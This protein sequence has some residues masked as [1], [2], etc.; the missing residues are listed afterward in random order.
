MGR[1]AR[2]RKEQPEEFAERC[3]SSAD[4]ADRELPKLDPP[5]QPTYVYTYLV[6]KRKRV[7]KK[8]HRVKTEMSLTIS[9]TAALNPNPERDDLWNPTF[10]NT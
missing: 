6:R 8:D 5:T 2:Q 9:L 10:E 1:T 3:G 7:G 4:Q